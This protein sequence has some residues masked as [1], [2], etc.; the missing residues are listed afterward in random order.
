MS[1]VWPRACIACHR[2][3]AWS[4]P[5]CDG[6]EGRHFAGCK[7]PLH[8]TVYSATTVHRA[9]SPAFADAVPYAIVLVRADGGGLVMGRARGFSAEPAIGTPV[10]VVRAGLA[11]DVIPHSEG[12]A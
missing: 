9:P 1:D 2:V 5:V 12:P 3:Q 6:C 10:Q 4:R 11:L 7:E 8:G